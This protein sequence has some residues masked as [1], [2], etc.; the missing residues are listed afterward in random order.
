LPALYEVPDGKCPKK[1][2]L[3]LA[4]IISGFL[5]DPILIATSPMPEKLSR[6]P[7]SALST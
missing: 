4:E 1:V 5:S 3:P 2:S 6:A 7:E